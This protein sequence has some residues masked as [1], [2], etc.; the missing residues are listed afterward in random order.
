MDGYTALQQRLNL[1]DGI[2][3]TPDWSAA[4]SDHGIF[5][6]TAIEQKVS[7]GGG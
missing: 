2:P 5:L 4:T 1:N 7:S 3:Y 6:F